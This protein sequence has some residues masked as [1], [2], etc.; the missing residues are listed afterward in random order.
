[1]T[2]IGKAIFI[3]NHVPGRFHDMALFRRSLQKQ[4]SMLEKK[5][6]EIGIKD[7]SSLTEICSDSWAL[8]CDKTYK[9]LNQIRRAVVP[10]K[11]KTLQRNGNQYARE[12]QRKIL[13]D[14][15]IVENYFG[16]LVQL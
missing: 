14:Q 13:A 16:R 3:S 11:K 8:L 12:S 9:G 2:S 6:N 1:M 7:N 4:K 15:I 5:K 10:Q